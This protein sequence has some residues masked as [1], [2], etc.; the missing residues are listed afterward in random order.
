MYSFMFFSSGSDARLYT[1]YSSIFNDTHLTCTLAAVKSY[2]IC[3][4]KTAGFLFVR[5]YCFVVCFSF[6]QFVY[7]THVDFSIFPSDLKQNFGKHF[8]HFF[9]LENYWIFHAMPIMSLF[10]FFCFLFWLHLNLRCTKNK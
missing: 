4:C 2:G 1:L 5:C 3:I 6:L 8:C 9:P 10:F 7:I